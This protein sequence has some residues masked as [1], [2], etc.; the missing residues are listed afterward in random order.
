MNCLAEIKLDWL[1]E[2]R[3]TANGMECVWNAAFESQCVSL[4]EKKEKRKKRTAVQ[5]IITIIIIKK[6]RFI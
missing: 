3:A 6:I 1:K 4:E 5:I 2:R